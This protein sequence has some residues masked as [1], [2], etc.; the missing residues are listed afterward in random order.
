MKN[1]DVVLSCASLRWCQGRE[2]NPLSQTSPPVRSSAPLRPSLA[3]SGWTSR[4]SRAICCVFCVSDGLHHPLDPE[5][6]PTG[7]GHRRARESVKNDKLGILPCAAHH[8]A[9]II[10]LVLLVSVASCFV[11]L[12]LP[13]G[14][15]VEHR[16]LVCCI[17][18][19]VRPQW[20][21]NHGPPPS[22]LPRSPG[23][24]TLP[25]GMRV[26]KPG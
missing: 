20:L 26:C 18:I 4:P 16:L 15:V 5:P 10:D 17:I 3:G 23:R 14:L 7:T 25:V 21:L 1:S 8:C 9:C 24:R 19:E 12:L 11:F 22:A 2:S 13:I 6:A